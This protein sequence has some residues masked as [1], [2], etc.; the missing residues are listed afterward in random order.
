MILKLQSDSKMT[1]GFFNYL[2]FFPEML[3]KKYF[4]HIVFERKRF[5]WNEIDLHFNNI[6][7]D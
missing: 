7:D 4:Q 6:H 3:Y 2:T 1:I 5:I